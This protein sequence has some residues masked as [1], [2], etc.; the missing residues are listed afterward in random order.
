M[1][2]YKI[3]SFT[4]LQ[5]MFPIQRLECQQYRVSSV[6]RKTIETPHE[7]MNSRYSSSHKF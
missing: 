4:I 5:D 7:S 1:N 3:D 6:P 2:V